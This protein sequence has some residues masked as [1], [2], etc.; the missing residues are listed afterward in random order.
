[1]A[2]PLRIT[3]RADSNRRIP[4]PPGAISCCRGTLSNPWSYD[5]AIAEGIDPADAPA[6]CVAEYR[7][8]L[9]GSDDPLLNRHP[10]WVAL[11]SRRERLLAML[12]KLRRKQLAC[13]CPLTKPCHVDVIC[14]L[15]NRPESEGANNA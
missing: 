15:A 7:L 1:M 10:R 2:H 8:W 9:Q 14:E 3:L 4:L 13:I 11:R 6:F 12:P 5:E